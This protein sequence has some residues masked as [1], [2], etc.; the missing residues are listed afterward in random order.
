MACPYNFDY[1][2][3]NWLLEQIFDLATGHRHDGVDSRAVSGSTDFKTASFDTT[4]GHDHDGTDS[5]LLAYQTY[6]AGIASGDAATGATLNIAVA[7]MRAT[8]A[9]LAS[10]VY[11]ATTAYIQTVAMISTASFRVTMHAA[12]GPCTIS[13]AVLRST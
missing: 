12:C 3:Q 10:L 13:Y 7:A 11:S 6:K 9:I 1:Y 8:D 5:K 2:N 4:S